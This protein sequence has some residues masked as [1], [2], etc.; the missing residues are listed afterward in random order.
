LSKKSK[1]WH[2]TD[3]DLKDPLAVKRDCELQ[4]AGNKIRD[5]KL[6]THKIPTSN[7]NHLDPLVVSHKE[8]VDFYGKPN[9]NDPLSIDKK[10]KR[11]NSLEINPKQ[12]TEVP[13]HVREYLKLIKSTFP[14]EIYYSFKDCIRQFR[15]RAFTKHDVVDAVA[16]LFLVDADNISKEKRIQLFLDFKPFVGTL[17]KYDEL[18]ELKLSEFNKIT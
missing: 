10:Q 14:L 7:S 5:N 1:Y 3:I 9:A 12:A 4:Y 8:K 16:K 18:F 6:D 11:R 13:A 2:N 15:K 17:G